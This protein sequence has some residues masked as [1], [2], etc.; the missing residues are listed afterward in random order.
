M[1]W[2]R[3]T[4]AYMWAHYYSE[5]GNWKAYDEDI[6]I[7]CGGRKKWYNPK[8]HKMENEDLVKHVWFL[9]NLKTGKKLDIEFK[10]LKQA[11]EYAEAQQEN[12]Y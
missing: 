5:D 1:K 7:K 11:K 4:Q 8:T 9:V 6:H 10:T 3:E 2:R 12:N